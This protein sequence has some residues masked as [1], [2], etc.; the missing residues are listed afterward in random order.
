[1]TSSSHR[2]EDET[3]EKREKSE[4]GKQ[5]AQ[6]SRRLVTRETTR[7]V[8]VTES[9]LKGTYDD[10]KNYSFPERHQLQDVPE[11]IESES[12]KEEDISIGLSSKYEI[13]LKKPQ[14]SIDLNLPSPVE[15]HPEFRVEAKK[16][17]DRIKDLQGIITKLRKENYFVEQWNEK[18]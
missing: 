18:Q 1:M 3:E 16:R 2:L 8:S 17:K 6:C 12:T 11:T 15:E 4:K 10:E 9:T 5:I 7:S 14:A 13:K